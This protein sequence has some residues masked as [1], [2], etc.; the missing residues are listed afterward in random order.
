MGCNG[1]YIT[2]TCYPDAYNKVFQILK[3]LD[4]IAFS[5]KDSH[6]DAAVYSIW[7]QIKTDE[8]NEMLENYIVSKLIPF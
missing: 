1:V 2:R 3:N 5:M 7:H 6:R 8:F 4:F